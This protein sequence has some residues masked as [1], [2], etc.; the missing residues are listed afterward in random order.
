MCAFCP[1]PCLFYSSRFWRAHERHAHKPCVRI[2]RYVMR[3][4]LHRSGRRK[5]STNKYSSTGRQAHPAVEPGS[6]GDVVALSGL[7][8]EKRY[9]PFVVDLLLLLLL[10]LC[11]S[12][13]CACVRAWTV[14]AI[15]SGHRRCVC[16]SKPSQRVQHA[17]LASLLPSLPPSL[18]PSFLSSFL[19]SF[20]P[21][22]G[23]INR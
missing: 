23:S 3:A 14:I 19:P 2:D 12:C 9:V 4:K 11:C 18:L 13:V 21:G 6:C 1:T 20:L 16:E 10:S 15:A 22:V 7:Q 5:T 17:F 8:L